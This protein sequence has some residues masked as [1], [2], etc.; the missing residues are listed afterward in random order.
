[1]TFNIYPDE[2]VWLLPRNE[3]SAI[4]GADESSTP[5]PVPVPATAIPATAVPPTPTPIPT[6]I[7]EKIIFTSYT[8]QPG[9][10][11]YSIAARFGWRST[12]SLMAKYNIAADDLEPGTVLTPFPVA[13]PDYCPGRQPYVVEENES[14]YIISQTVGTT[15]ETLKEINN[16]DEKYTVY[17]TDVICVP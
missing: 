10:T 15:L 3:T 6:P 14:A 13:N 8:V 1:V 5:A 4:G 11:L 2:T 16:L 9:D 7:P 17:V 12:I